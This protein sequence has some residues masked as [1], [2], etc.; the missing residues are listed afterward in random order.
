MASG[1]GLVHEDWGVERLGLRGHR[2]GVHLWSC[3]RP[4]Q[5]TNSTSGASPLGGDSPESFLAGQMCSAEQLGPSQASASPPDHAELSRVSGEG[6][7][8]S[9]E[10]AQLLPHTGSLRPFRPT[11][12]MDGPKRQGN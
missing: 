4:Q 3:C 11:G 9:R 8:T 1:R 10:E 7:E 6:E 2:L 12:L 5:V